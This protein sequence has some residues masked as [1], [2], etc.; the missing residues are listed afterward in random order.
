MRSGVFTCA[1]FLETLS[2]LLLRDHLLTS[3]PNNL[4]KERTGSKKRPWTLIQ[5]GPQN[6]P[7]ILHL[8][9]PANARMYA[10]DQPLIQ[11]PS[12]FTTIDHYCS[13]T[14]KRLLN[15][16]TNAAHCY[17]TS[18]EHT[19]YLSGWNYLTSHEA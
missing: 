17:K 8:G 1:P 18:T 11:P 10:H 3:G 9:C 19:L 14:L 7:R 4:L 16:H 2:C 6:Q 15:T 12:C 13:T 5:T